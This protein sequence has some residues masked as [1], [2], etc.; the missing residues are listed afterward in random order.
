M[1]GPVTN[2]RSLDRIVGDGEEPAGKVLRATNFVLY[3]PAVRRNSMESQSCWTRW[4]TRRGGGAG[5]AGSGRSSRALLV[6]NSGA[7]VLRSSGT[8]WAEIFLSQPGESPIS[9]RVQGHFTD[10]CWIPIPEK[11]SADADA[12]SASIECVVASFVFPRDWEDCPPQ[13]CRSMFSENPHPT[14]WLIASSIYEYFLYFCFII[15]CWRRY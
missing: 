3:L 9:V 5:D 11:F 1:T 2:K 14:A 15:I 10:W 12:D 4:L 8:W 7:V 6:S 13:Y